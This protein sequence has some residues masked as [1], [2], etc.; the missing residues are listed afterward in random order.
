MWHTDLLPRA[1]AC[2]HGPA[3]LGESMS[4][5]I[6]RRVFTGLSIGAILGCP[7]RGLVA[8]AAES[9]PVEQ[10]PARRTPRIASDW[11]RIVEYPDRHLNDFCLFR[12]EQ[13]T[14]HA[15]GIMGTGTWASET[16]LFHSTGK[17][18]R[19]RFENRPPLFEAMPRW[20]GGRQ[21]RNAAPQKHA[22][23]VVF[24]DGLYHLF[25]RRPGGTML[26]VRSPDPFHW[27]DEVELVFEE[28]DARDVC[29]VKIGG[30]F[31]MYY[32]QAAVV[33]GAMRSCDLLRTSKDL[34]DWSEATVVYVDT[35]RESGHSSLESPF[36][37]PRP[38]GFYLFVRN[39]LLEEDTVT[40]VSF[41]EDPAR[42]PSGAHP[43]FAELKHVHAPEIVEC[44]GR[45]YIARVSGPRH[46]N[47]QAPAAGGWVEVAELQFR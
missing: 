17:G 33:D 15:I 31:L 6:T 20:V 25:Y 39:R 38:E 46:A 1:R 27:P 34:R 36:V 42:F 7:R 23:F 24:H 11:F 19:E 14:W 29:I 28:R 4:S 9:P 3:R 45:Y 30:A 37:V 8:R 35:S 44:D 16:S 5:S 32:C 21:S 47:R 18:L 26:V 2:K 12:D 43:W 10:G 41:S 22:P 13:G 40:T